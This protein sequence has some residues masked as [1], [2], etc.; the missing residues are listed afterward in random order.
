[1]TMPPPT[2]V[3]SVRNTELATPAETPATDSARPA[4]VA[5]LSMKMGYNG[6]Q[7]LNDR[8]SAKIQNG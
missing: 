6:A 3:P 1:M 2:P 7:E 8:L 5:S 4:T